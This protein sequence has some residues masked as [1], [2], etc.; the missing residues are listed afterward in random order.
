MGVLTQSDEADV[1]GQRPVLGQFWDR[2]MELRP[3]NAL[4]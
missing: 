1:L 4:K 2:A 3:E